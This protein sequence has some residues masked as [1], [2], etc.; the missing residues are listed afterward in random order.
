MKFNHIKFLR[1]GEVFGDF[2]LLVRK[3]RSACILVV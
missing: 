3:P 2:G 1:D